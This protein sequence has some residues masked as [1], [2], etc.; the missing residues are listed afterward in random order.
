MLSCMSERNSVRCCAQC[1]AVANRLR[2]G[3]REL[4]ASLDHRGCV[5][6]AA[7][8][9]GLGHKQS[10]RD[11]AIRLNQ[12]LGYIEDLAANITARCTTRAQPDA[13]RAANRQEYITREQAL[14]F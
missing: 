7:E 14:R 6:M 5:I 1:R 12:P 8:T 4:V 9:I 2:A 13:E 11:G 3:F 10:A